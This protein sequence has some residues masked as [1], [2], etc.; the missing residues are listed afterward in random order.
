LSEIFFVSGEPIAWKRPRR[1]KSDDKQWRFT[2]PQVRSWQELVSAVWMIH[3]RPTFTGPLIVRLDFTM[4]KPKSPAKEYPRQDCDNLAKGT[5][6]ALN[7]LAFKDDSQIVELSITK[8][9]GEPP[10]V[11]VTLD[12]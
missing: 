4:T 5:I 11:L 8:R 9:Y 1:G 12:E 10:G 3:G 6:D 7:G 2:D